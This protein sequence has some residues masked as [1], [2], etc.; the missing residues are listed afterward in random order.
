LGVPLSYLLLVDDEVD[1]LEI[2]YISVQMHFTGRILTCSSGN[3][4]I[5]IIKENGEPFLVVTDFNMPNGN[6]A[7]LQ[8]QL[9]T[10]YPNAKLIV[11]SGNPID[12]IRV[13]L[14]GAYGYVSKPQFVQPLCEI[15]KSLVLKNEKNTTQHIAPPEYVSIPL[16]YLLKLGVVDMDTYLKIGVSKYVKILQR[17]DVFYQPDA[18]KLIQKKIDFMFVKREDANKI[19]TQFEAFITQHTN[20]IP[21]QT[22]QKLALSQVILETT[23]SITK[24]MGWTPETVSMAKQAVGFAI[25]QVAGKTDWKDILKRATSE[26]KYAE[27]VSL[28]SLLSCV[29]TQAAGWSNEATQQKLVLAALLHDYFLEDEIYCIL[30]GDD[31]EHVKGISVSKDYLDHPIK[32]AEFARKISNLPPD[33]D[34]IILQHHEHP[35][36]SGFPR[37]LTASQISPL[38]AIFIICHDLI[39]FTFGKVV[40]DKLVADFWHAYEEKY[41]R[42]PFKKISLVMKQIS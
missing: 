18:D 9:K 39:N 33:I 35:D 34:N 12:E 40:D 36:G 7:F 20:S 27:H 15:I 24:G 31:L 42:D 17:G 29:V 19:L 22:D 8:E 10:L 26:S 25:S 23:I 13:K 21:P 3:D 11:C 38:S 37:G 30:S 6:G 2:L 14:P 28:L 4:A 1:I 41:K 32:A 16:G 5:A